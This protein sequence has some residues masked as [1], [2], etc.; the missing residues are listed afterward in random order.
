MCG[1]IGYTGTRPVVEILAT[2]LERL[3]YRGYDSA[4]I[5]VV[6][7]G[8]YIE[9]TKTAGKISLLRER[10]HTEPALVGTTGIGHTRWATHGKPVEEN[11]H[12]LLDCKSQIAVVHNGII[13]NYNVLKQVLEKKG[14]KFQSETDS[15]VL[16][17]LISKIYYTDG[18]SFPEAVQA[19]LQEEM[20]ELEELM[21][22]AVAVRVMRALEVDSQEMEQLALVGIVVV[23][24]HL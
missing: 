14:V 15:E 3:E 19:A 24:S 11:A 2:A 1:I 5:A 10:L 4:G 13:E 9:T 7:Q 18:L 16:V 20:E 23:D 8:N 12:P 22:M 17:Q 21:E 6:G